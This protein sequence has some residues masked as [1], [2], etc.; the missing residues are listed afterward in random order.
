[1]ADNEQLPPS[2]LNQL[3][4][5]AKIVGCLTLAIG[6]VAIPNGALGTLALCMVPVSFLVG[7]ARLPL[8]LVARRYLGLAPVLAMLAGL[9][10]VATLMPNVRWSPHGLPP[11]VIVVAVTIKAVLALTIMVVLVTRT[12]F[13]DLIWGLQAL[14]VP[15]L[16]LVIV[17]SLFR[18]AETLTDELA[19]MRRA[20]AARNYQPR[21]LGD[22]PALGH[23]LGSLFL[24]SYARSERVHRAMLSR[25]WE[26]ATPAVARTGR[27]PVFRVRDAVFL[28]AMACSGLL[29]LLSALAIL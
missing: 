13:A 11:W 16:L 28:T 9:L 5:R 2:W 4:P 3:D 7:V 21:W 27:A 25:G 26:G 10:L 18:W 6:I 8:R 14:R 19:R 20:L 24:R 17:A 15:R 1:M 12:S 23:L 29:A 22:A